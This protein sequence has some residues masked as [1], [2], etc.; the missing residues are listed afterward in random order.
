MHQAP[1]RFTPK[2][3]LP[4]T[5]EFSAPADLV[6][7]FRTGTRALRDDWFERY[8]NVL[9]DDKCREQTLNQPTNHFNE[10]YSAIQIYE[11]FGW[12]SLVE[13]YE[14]KNH[15]RKRALVPVVLGRPELADFVLM[16]A[17]GRKRFDKSL[18]G[19]CPDLLC[20]A[21]DFSDWFFCEAKKVGEPTN[22]NQKLLFPKLEELSGQPVRWATIKYE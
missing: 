3:E 12:L 18:E 9:F 2:S 11:R 5:F 22:P 7:G 4:K 21:P 20:Y 8:R 6:A 15:P 1:I 17:E 14:F 13:Q 10:W 16:Q 19:Q